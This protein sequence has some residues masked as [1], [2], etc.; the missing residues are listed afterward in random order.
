MISPG[1]SSSHQD[2]EAIIREL[3]IRVGLLQSEVEQLRREHATLKAGITHDIVALARRYLDTGRHLSAAV[4]NVDGVIFGGWDRAE[5]A[6]P[7]STD[8]AADLSPAA[9]DTRTG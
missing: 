6:S 3:R 7:G 2:S 1:D 5:P 9:R 4:R 8:N